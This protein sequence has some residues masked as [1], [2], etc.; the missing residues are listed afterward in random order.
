MIAKRGTRGERDFLSVEE[1][2]EAVGINSIGVYINRRLTT[3]AKRVAL[4]P[5]YTVDMEEGNI[6]ETRRLVQW[7]DQDAVN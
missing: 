2:M 5:F 6:Q 7:W 1:A 3:I 4:R